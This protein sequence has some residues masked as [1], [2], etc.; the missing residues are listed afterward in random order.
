MYAMAAPKPEEFPTMTPQEIGSL[1]N[2]KETV[3]REW[4]RANDLVR[5]SGDSAKKPL[6]RRKDVM[7]AF[8]ARAVQVLTEAYPA[9]AK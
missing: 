6:Y 4:I 1:I 3:T 5:V 9:F 8:E 2:R 7:R